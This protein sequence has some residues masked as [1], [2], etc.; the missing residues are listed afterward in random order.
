M[1]VSLTKSYKLN[2][3]NY[4]SMEMSATVSVEGSDLYDEEG[5]AD[6]DPDDLHA[7]L[8]KY[9][10][11][12]LEAMLAPELREAAELSAATDSMLFSDPPKTPARR[13]K[14][15]TR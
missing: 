2:M 15:R 13:E 9:A 5:L 1:K 6:V 14:T 4:E 3:G 11:E 8:H 10:K 12:R 7:E